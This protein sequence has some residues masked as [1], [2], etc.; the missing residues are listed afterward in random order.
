MPGGDQQN[1]NA[2]ARGSAAAGLAAFSV[3]ISIYS[4]QARARAC[5]TGPGP[6]YART[7]MITK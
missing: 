1:V 4:F 6:R 2:G 3:R 5:R 7:E